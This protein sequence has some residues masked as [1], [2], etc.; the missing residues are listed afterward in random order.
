MTYKADFVDGDVLRRS[1]TGDGVEVD[2]D[3]DYTPTIYAGI[4]NGNLSK[5]D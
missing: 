5:L 4:R 3:T 2:R 1:L